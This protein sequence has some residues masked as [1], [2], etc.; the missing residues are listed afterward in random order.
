[1][2]TELWAVIVVGVPLVSAAVYLAEKTWGLSKRIWKRIGTAEDSGSVG[3]NR[4]IHT[5]GAAPEPASPSDG[6]DLSEMFEAAKSTRGHDQRD[7]ALRVVAEIAVKR[8][9]YDI[10]IK[11]GAASPSHD[12]LSITT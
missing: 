8:R 12:G 5:V 3:M 10:A 6:A 4:E 11:A 2:T 9:R 1:M 7:R